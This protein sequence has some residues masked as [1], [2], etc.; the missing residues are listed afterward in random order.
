MQAPFLPTLSHLFPSLRADV[1]PACRSGAA[2]VMVPSDCREQC[3]IHRNTPHEEDLGKD[4]IICTLCVSCM[5]KYRLLPLFLLLSNLLNAPLRH[6][7]LFV[8]SPFKT[9]FQLYSSI[10]LHWLSSSCTTDT[11]S[12]FA[13]AHRFRRR[14]I[15]A[16]QQTCAG[17]PSHQ[18]KGK[19]NIALLQTLHVS[20]SS[21][22]STIAQH[23]HASLMFA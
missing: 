13:H 23:H 6:N 9:A 8:L 15:L 11:A 2:C 1:R 22:A 18:P 14:H 19:R 21:F 7:T 4:L 3:Y 20:R 5:L 12:P 16:A 17:S 10:F